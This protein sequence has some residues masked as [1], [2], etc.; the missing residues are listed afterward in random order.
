MAP[1][2]SLIVKSTS[3]KR[4]GPIIKQ[5][6]VKQLKQ[7]QIAQ[8]PPNNPVITSFIGKKRVPEGSNGPTQAYI[9]IGV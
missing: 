1:P 7:L 9:Q 5:K 6:T 2:A 4:V 8:A 3:A